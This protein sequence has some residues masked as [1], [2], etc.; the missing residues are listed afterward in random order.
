M[1]KFFRSF[2]GIVK[3]LDKDAAKPSRPAA[4]LSAPPGNRDRWHCHLI[5]AT[6]GAYCPV[7]IPKTQPMASRKSTGGTICRPATSSSS[8]TIIRCFA[9]R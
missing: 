3:E 4:D 5:G 2:M 9:A 6:I 1:E 7:R 8:P